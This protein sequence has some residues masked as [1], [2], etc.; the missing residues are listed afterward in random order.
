[1]DKNNIVSA[2]LNRSTRI[3]TISIGYDGLFKPV[4]YEYTDRFIV[5]FDNAVSPN[6][7]G[8][9]TNLQVKLSSI[10]KPIY[11]GVIN[12]SGNLILLPVPYV[13][14]ELGM[15]LMLRCPGSS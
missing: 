11:L 14:A 15:M 3:L 7:G 6:N 13:R 9:G 12:E 5:S 4:V 2:S 10:D 8:R 1:M